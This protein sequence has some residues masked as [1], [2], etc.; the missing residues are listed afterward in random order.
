MVSQTHFL[1]GLSLQG[2]VDDLVDNLEGMTRD[3]AHLLDIKGMLGVA[4]TRQG[5]FA[6]ADSI[7]QVLA[8]A[9]TT[10]MRGLLALWRA[11]IAAQRGAK[12]QAVRLL[13]QAFREGTW[14]Q[15]NMPVDGGFWHTDPDFEPLRGYEPCERLIAPK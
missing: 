4:Y 9:D 15:P 1:L 10:D 2:R 11:R 3:S 7:D 14:F 13:D 8:A 5:D 6:A 12:E